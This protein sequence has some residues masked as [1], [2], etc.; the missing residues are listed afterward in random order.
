[1]IFSREAE[2]ILQILQPNQHFC[3]SHKKVSLSLS[4][5][6]IYCF[7]ILTFAYRCARY[8]RKSTLGYFA[9]WI[10]LLYHH[11]AFLVMSLRRSACILVDACSRVKL[12]QNV[13]KG[14]FAIALFR[15]DVTFKICEILKGNEKQ[16]SNLDSP[17]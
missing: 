10:P 11:F 14:R 17:Y 1:M 5:I 2:R 6:Y 13:F 3:G 7:P 9:L 8:I 12:K 15:N 16:D 4:Y